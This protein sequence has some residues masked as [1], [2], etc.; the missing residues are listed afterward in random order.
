MQRTF[1]IISLVCCVICLA[2]SIWLAT[3]DRSNQTYFIVLFF[4]IA[5]LWLGYNVAKSGR[6]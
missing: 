6:K 5:C 2:A 3:V 1:L 4:S